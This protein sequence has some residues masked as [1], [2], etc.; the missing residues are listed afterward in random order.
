MVKK[1]TYRKMDNLIGYYELCSIFLES[2]T[3]DKSAENRLKLQM[4]VTLPAL[5]K[6]YNS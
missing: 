6:P 5:R 4:E 2:A 1:S 3:T